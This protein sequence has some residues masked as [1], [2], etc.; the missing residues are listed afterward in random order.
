[1]IGEETGPEAHLH[2]VDPGWVEGIVRQADAAGIP[3]SVK[4]PLALRRG[5]P[6]RSE[7][8]EEMAALVRGDV[9]P[10]FPSFEDLLSK[11]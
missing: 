5:M 10:G 3:V 1:M 8:P 6:E 2:P 4:E 7:M 9:R 11:G